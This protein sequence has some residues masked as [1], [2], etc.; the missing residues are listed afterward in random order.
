MGDLQ[1]RSLCKHAT[2]DVQSAKRY[3]VSHSAAARVVPGPKP[4]PTDQ[5]KVPRLYRAFF[6]PLVYGLIYSPLYGNPFLNRHSIMESIK[7]IFRVIHIPF[8]PRSFL[9]AINQ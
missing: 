1:L 5:R 6:W 7:V 8:I 4:T 3:P 9:L 2:E